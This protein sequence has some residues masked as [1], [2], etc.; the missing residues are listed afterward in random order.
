M[1][2]SPFMLD[3]QLL[4]DLTTMEG[5]REKIQETMKKYKAFKNYKLTAFIDCGEY[6]CTF[7]TDRAGRVVKVTN[8]YDSKTHKAWARESDIQKIAAKS[9]CAPRIFA[10]EIRDSLG[11]VVMEEVEMVKDVRIIPEPCDKKLRDWRYNCHVYDDMSQLSNEAQYAFITTMIDMIAVGVVHLDNHMENMGFINRDATRPCFIDFGSAQLRENMSYFDRLWALAFSM[12]IILE[13]TP[14]AM[15]VNTVFYQL[16]LKIWH[17]S[18]ASQYHM[19]LENAISSDID[20]ISP[21]YIDM[22]QGM[23]YY[24][25]LLELNVPERDQHKF[26]KTIYDIRA[27]R[28]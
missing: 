15:L 23:Y 10:N 14:P 7:K 22:Y 3:K 12:G 13:R 20:K 24:A 4:S 9:G 18:S 25:K 1:D 17:I 16:F 19:I 5:Q 8:Q 21:E 6:G 2:S 27:M 11:I 28:Q 26:T